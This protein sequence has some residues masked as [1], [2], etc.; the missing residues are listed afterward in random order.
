MAA[1]G[2]ELNEMKPETRRTLL[3]PMIVTIVGLTTAMLIAAI[4][5]GVLF[6]G[7]S[8]K[9]RARE[10]FGTVST[11]GSPSTNKGPNAMGLT[12]IDNSLNYV[13]VH[14]DNYRISMPISLPSGPTRFIVHNNSEI[15]HSFKVR[16][17][18]VERSL[19]HDIKPYQ[20]TVLAVSLAPG[21]YTAR[22][23]LADHAE[24]SQALHFTVTSP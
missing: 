2:M 21:N 10:A 23:P 11:G 15:E 19:T 3:R 18:D 4:I 14:L 8:P 22:C 7:P 12:S 5:G 9:S 16:G 24:Q 17:N 1:S 6:R 13:D 20:T